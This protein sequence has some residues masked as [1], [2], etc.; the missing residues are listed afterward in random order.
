MNRPTRWYTC[1][2]ARPLAAGG[3]E[4]G[5]GWLAEPAEP[6]PK[7]ID[8]LA[9]RSQRGLPGPAEAWTV[10]P[11]TSPVNGTGARTA[12]LMTAAEAGGPLTTL[13]R[14]GGRELTAAGLGD[15]ATGLYD[16]AGA[17]LCDPAAA[18]PPTPQPASAPPR[19]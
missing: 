11:T 5:Q 3:P 7:L 12:R 13:V 14:T 16:L 10:R 19:A 6:S 8:T 17:G 9:S 15:P 4:P 1:L 2:I 18:G